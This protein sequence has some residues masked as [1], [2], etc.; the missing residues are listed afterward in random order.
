MKK[1]NAKDAVKAA[2]DRFCE[3]ME[4]QGTACCSDC[5]CWK[6]CECEEARAIKKAIENVKERPNA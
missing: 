5:D 2:T 3:V 1:I 4:E 6:K